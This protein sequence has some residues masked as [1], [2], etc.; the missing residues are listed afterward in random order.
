MLNKGF[1]PGGVCFCWHQ[2]AHQNLP[3][4]ARARWQQSRL[5]HSSRAESFLGG[6]LL[7]I[8]LAEEYVL[9]MF[10]SL[11]ILWCH[12]VLVRKGTIYL[13]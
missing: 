8:M 4:G 13:L 10:N 11:K 2:L 3:A 5:K 1:F 12:G 6:V 7:G 9:P